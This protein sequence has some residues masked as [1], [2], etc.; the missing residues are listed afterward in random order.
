M[1]ITETQNKVLLAGCVIVYQPDVAVL[2]NIKSYLTHL[3]VLYVIDNSEN[4]DKQVVEAITVLGAKIIYLPQLTNIGV[5][6][7]L[8]SAAGKA[9][10]AGY[11]FLLTMDQDSCF[12]SDEFLTTWR[13]EFVQD[14]KIGL[15]AASYTD[16]YDRWVRSY[17]DRY[18]EIHFAVTSG[19]IISLNAWQSIGGF[20]DKLFIDEVDHEYNLK[21]RKQGFKVLTSKQILMAHTVGEVYGGDNLDGS[22]RKVKLHSPLRYYYMA[23]NVLYICSKFFFTDFGF[24]IS[25]YWYLVK[26]LAKITLRYPEKKTYLKFF[27]AGVKDFV[28]SKYGRYGG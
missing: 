17:N 7:A 25:R 8:N 6:A 5:A 23:R 27:F 21:L 1:S 4:A 24:V 20:A 10:Q 19:N 9:R 18:N 28:A 3:D 14:S 26:M 2:T 15:V 11:D 12:L 22:V 13:P 16:K